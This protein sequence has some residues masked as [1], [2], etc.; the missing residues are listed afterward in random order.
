[1]REHIYTLFLP[2]G[3]KESHFDRLLQI[4]VRPMCQHNFGDNRMLKT[5]NSAV[6]NRIGYAALNDTKQ[7]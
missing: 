4:G 3:K 7:S 2:S 5:E 6:Y 1:M